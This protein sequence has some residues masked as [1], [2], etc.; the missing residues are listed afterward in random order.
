[1]E[2]PTAL[3]RPFLHGKQATLPWPS[4]QG[5]CPPQLVTGYVVLAPQACLA[6]LLRRWALE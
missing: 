1:M 6:W 5:E 3:I 2:R 4:P